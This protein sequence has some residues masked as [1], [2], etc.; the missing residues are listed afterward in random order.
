MLPLMVL[1]G[2]APLAVTA[3]TPQPAQ[4][5]ERFVV[6]LEGA[7]EVRWCPMQV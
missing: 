7:Q 6:P 2:A 5:E 1:L 3:V 4:S